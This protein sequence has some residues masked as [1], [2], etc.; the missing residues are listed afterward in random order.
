VEKLS[1]DSCTSHVASRKLKLIDALQ[2]RCI[3]SELLE[4]MKL[5]L[6]SKQNCVG[7][8]AL[9]DKMGKKKVNILIQRNLVHL[10][11]CHATFS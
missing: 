1:P 6:A 3:S 7:Y 2:T 11:P 9:C 5:L 4:V 8:N 10:R